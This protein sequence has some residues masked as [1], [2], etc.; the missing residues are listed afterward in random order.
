MP[1]KHLTYI[2]YSRISRKHILALKTRRSTYMPI[3]L[4]SFGQQV[5]Q[6]CD[7]W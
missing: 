5:F 7:G 1:H 4:S 6:G 2:R 3:G